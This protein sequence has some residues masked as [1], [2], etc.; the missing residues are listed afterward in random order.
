MFIEIM[1]Y[2]TRCFLS[3]AT[4]APTS[5]ISA[6]TFPF[7]IQK[8]TISFSRR[9]R[10]RPRLVGVN[11]VGMYHLRTRTVPLHTPPTC[12]CFTFHCMSKTICASRSSAMAPRFIS[13]MAYCTYK[14]KKAASGTYCLQNNVF[15]LY[16]FVWIRL[17]RL[18]S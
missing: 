9:G 7:A 10:T 5:T 2:E 6:R 14:Y 17:A 4:I 15:L 13:R 3:S 16:P 12:V 11:E 8:R 1:I 18:V